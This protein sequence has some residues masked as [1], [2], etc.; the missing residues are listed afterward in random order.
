MHPGFEALLDS[1]LEAANW[2]EDQPME[3]VW[4]GSIWQDFPHLNNATGNVYTRTS[5][6][7]VFSLYLD[8]FGPE[9]SS[10]L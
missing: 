4:H 6:N 10:N 9:G 1:S 3:D 8:W 5:G 2:S 7:L